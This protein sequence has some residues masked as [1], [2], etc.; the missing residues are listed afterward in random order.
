MNQTNRT[1]TLT[2]DAF[3][4]LLAVNQRDNNGNG[5]NWTAAYDPLGRRVQT[6]CDMVLTNVA[7]VGPNATDSTIASWYDP[8][9]EFEEV[10]VQVDGVVYW[11]TLGPDVNGIYGGMQGVGG[12]ESVMQDGHTSA[13]GV[14]Q[15]YFGNVVGTIANGALS[16]NPSRFSSYGPVPGYQSPAL[17]P[18]VGL[19][20]SLGW[21]GER[22]DETGLICLGARH[23]DPVAGRFLNADPLGHSASMDLYS[24]CGGDPVNSFDPDGRLSKGFYQGLQLGSSPDNAS[25]AFSLGY[26][27]GI[28]NDISQFLGSL[29]QPGQPAQQS[30]PS[31]PEHFWD[32]GEGTYA[33]YYNQLADQRNEPLVQQEAAA[34]RQVLTTALEYSP[35]VMFPEAAPYYAAGAIDQA[36]GTR[37]PPG[38]SIGMVP[39]L[40]E[41][42]PEPNLGPATP[43][44]VTPP[45]A[46]ATPLAGILEGHAPGQG[47]TGVYDASTGNVS[48]A[49][50]TANA[51]IPAGWVARA[52]GHA[53]V[54]AAL[55]GDPA[56]QSGFAVV[57]QNDGSLN[58]TWKSGTLNPAPAFE[59]APT[60]RQAIINAVQ[61]A[62]GRKVNP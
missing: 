41:M 21:R 31:S 25:G 5:F 47:F 33:A 23:Y 4:R 59:V 48:L 40:P 1:Q 54:S 35:A 14:V 53:D 49:P 10:A 52:G 46:G 2:W 43:E 20:Q 37:P 50:S 58:I 6:T 44:P 16:W 62:T 38:T 18:E 9:V 56:N 11:K 26:G 55:G 3:D 45:G 24:F 61:T 29:S 17:S 30:Q 28:A 34:E 27:L 60:S 22:V 57:L 36:T 8:Q 39:F 7:V 19:A 32:I 12:V 13:V 42:G 51:E 15:D